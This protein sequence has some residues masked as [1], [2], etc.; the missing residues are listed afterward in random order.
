VP[1]STLLERL[2]SPAPDLCFYGLAPPKQ[3]TEPERLRAILEAQKARISALAPDALVVYDL[4]DESDRQAEARPF[5]FLPTLPPLG[6]AHELLGELTLPKIVYRCVAQDTHASFG[7]WLEALRRSNGPHLSVFVGAA[8][9]RP[10]SRAGSLSL[11]DAYTLARP[12]AQAITVGGIAIPERHARRG[13]EH[14]RLLQKA[15]A[16]CRFFVTQTVYDASATKSLLSDYARELRTRGGT[17]VPIIFTFSPCGS[18]RTLELLKWLG[19]AIPRWLE[20]ELLDARDILG[21][22]VRACEI[23]WDEVLSYARSKDLPVGVNVESVSIRKE[24]VDASVAL[25]TA[26]RERLRRP[27]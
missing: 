13:D 26:L 8:T 11:A 10:A 7:S 17:P 16:G 24:E 22:S 25:F 15:A 5:P 9:S 1:T 6:Y 27:G 21:A 4:Q 3:S 18:A 14:L 19:I 23:A 20:N 2:S 12:H